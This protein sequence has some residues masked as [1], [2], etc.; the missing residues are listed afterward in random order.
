MK[1]EQDAVYIMGESV[2]D[3]FVG[4]SS[5]GVAGGRP[6]AEV[7]SGGRA[8]RLGGR[9]RIRAGWSVRRVC[10]SCSRRRWTAAGDPDSVSM[11]ALRASHTALS[12]S[13]AMTCRYTGMLTLVG[14]I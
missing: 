1:V 11:E 6:R 14:R 3:V 2:W 10:R 13:A 8:M 12:P 4:S 9:L 7:T 5:V